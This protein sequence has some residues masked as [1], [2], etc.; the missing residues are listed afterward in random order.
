MGERPL[1]SIIVPVY[2]VSKYL[3][4]CLD[5][6]CAQEGINSEIIVVDDGSTDGSAEICDEYA[7]KH[8]N[9]KVIHKQNGGLAS[10]RN[11][12]LDVMNGDYVGFVDSDDYIEADM[13]KIL[14]QAMK[15]NESNIACCSCFRVIDGK[16]GMMEKPV[17]VPTVLV[18]N[19][20]IRSLLLN[21]E[22][23]YSAC[24]K[25]FNAELFRAVRFPKENL[26]S[27]DIPCIYG[28]LKSIDK[29][30]YIGAAKYYYRLVMTSISKKEFTSKNM[31]TLYYNM[32]ICD[33]VKKNMPELRKEAD[34][35]LV[36]CTASIYSHLM[37]DGKQKECKK[38]K[39]C[40]EKLLWKNAV[41]IV[42]NPCLSFN[43]KLM[44]LSVPLRCYSILMKLRSK[45]K[46][47]DLLEK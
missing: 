22:M 46:G 10:A 3:R 11:A 41:N 16:P 13:Y 20:I 4:E 30:V 42:N 14:F 38:E 29:V 43:G 33:D 15:K 7:G 36:Q 39:R 37:R 47:K 17:T 27:E 1:I 5:S 9:L 28:I 40:M 24:D 2:N 45:I 32:E 21:K 34:F 19:D 35:S 26:P 6:V 8:A 23:T 18:G 12:G 25:L 44:A 31:S